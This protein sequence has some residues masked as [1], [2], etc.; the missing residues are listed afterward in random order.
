MELGITPLNFKSNKVSNKTESNNS[1]SNAIR[2]L[3]SSIGAPVLRPALAKDTVSFSGSAVRQASD[4]AG[5]T[6]AKI[7]E[8]I[9]KAA[10]PVKKVKRSVE[11]PRHL[12][13]DDVAQSSDKVMKSRAY[14]VNYE[15]A[16]KVY[17]EAE[18]VFDYFKK[19]INKYFAPLVSD[20]S[21]SDLPLAFGNEGIVIGMKKAASICEKTASKDLRT[22]SEIKK[23]MSDIIR[24]RL[25]LRDASP[26][27]IEAV[28]KKLTE[29]VKKGDLEIFEIENY[30]LEPKYSYIPNKFLNPFEKLCRSKKPNDFRRTDKSIPSG[31]TAVHLSVRLPDGF[32]GEIQIMGA[33]VQMVKELE[34]FMYKVKNKKALLPKY[35]PIEERLA[36]LSDVENT[37]LQ[38]ATNAHTQEQYLAARLKE[39]KHTKSSRGAKF[40]PAPN[41]LDKRFDFNELYRMKI[42]CDKNAAKI[43]KSS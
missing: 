4:I 32:R 21:N 40:L 42:E 18:P 12:F 22:K 37:A 20:L 27:S 9:P 29:A 39:P 3:S 15:L 14:A 34:D 25:V 28:M 30:R 23:E 8:F 19:T 38:L 2:S 10:Q 35:R 7:V 41:Y 6:A 33:D 36:P 31:Y 24:G 13:S 43:A 17:A 1:V 11:K 16:K 26:Q 5:E